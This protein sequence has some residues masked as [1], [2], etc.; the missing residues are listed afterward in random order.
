LKGEEPGEPSPR[1]L[2]PEVQA[3]TDPS[4]GPA[5]P[6]EIE[7]RSTAAFER[8]LQ[9][10]DSTARRRVI[11][12]INSRSALW[13][14]D[15]RKAEKLFFRPYRFLLRGDLES[16]LCEIRVGKERRVIM[17]V[18]DD[19]VFGRVI[20]TLMRV[21]PKSQQEA[22]YVELGQRLYPGQILEIQAT[23]DP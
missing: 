17:A 21:V 12:A 23:E 6:G 11:D 8:D 13:L 10:L 3:V 9:G 14:E 7:F 19:P 16:S 5:V 2:P 4:A 18:D 1:P 20:I 15:R 22:A